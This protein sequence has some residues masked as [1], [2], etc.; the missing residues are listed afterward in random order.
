MESTL[1]DN[2]FRFLSDNTLPSMIIEEKSRY[3][4]KNFKSMASD[5]MIK[6]G[7]LYKVCLKVFQILHR[8]DAL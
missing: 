8:F 2:I 5:Y 4:R 3:A 6:E 7:S 1:Y